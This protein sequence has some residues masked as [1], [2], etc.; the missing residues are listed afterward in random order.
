MV[1]DFIDDDEDW[2]WCGESAYWKCSHHLA[3]HTQNDNSMKGHCSIEGCHVS[4]LDHVE[5]ESNTIP[6]PRSL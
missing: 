4:I 5:Y 2:L 1:Y 6:L 3:D